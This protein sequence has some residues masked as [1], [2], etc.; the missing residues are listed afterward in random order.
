MGYRLRMSG[1]IHDWL[2]DLHETDPSAAMLAGQALARASRA[3]RTSAPAPRRP[4]LSA[5]CPARF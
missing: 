4:H 2:A 1:E 3:P 5:A